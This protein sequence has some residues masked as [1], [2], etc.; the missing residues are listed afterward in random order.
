MNRINIDPSV[1]FRL[2]VNKDDAQGYFN[3]I[4]HPMDFSTI[5]GKIKSG[6]YKDIENFHTDMLLVRDNCVKYNRDPASQIRVDCDTVFGFYTVEYDKLKSRKPAKKKATGTGWDIG[7]Y[8]RAQKGAKLDMA[9]ASA[10]K[11]VQSQVEKLDDDIREKE[12][13][14]RDLTA[15]I[16]WKERLRAEFVPPVKLDQ[17]VQVEMKSK[18]RC[19]TNPTRVL[20]N[21]SARCY[22][23]NTTMTKRVDETCKALE[24]IHGADS[25]SVQDGLWLTLV[26]KAGKGAIQKYYS[27]LSRPKEGRVTKH[28]ERVTEAIVVRCVKYMYRNGSISSRKYTSLRQADLSFEC[29]GDELMTYQELVHQLKSIC[30]ELQVHEVAGVSG[31][32]RNLEDTLLKIASVY[33]EIDEKL[34]VNG[35]SLNWLK[36][37]RGHFSISVGADGAPA[38]KLKTHTS[39]LLSF[40]NLPEKVNSC[41]YQFLLFGADVPED[42]ASILN[43]VAEIASNME[44][45][46]KKVFMIG[47]TVVRFTL[48]LVPGDCKW[49]ATACGEL[50]NAAAYPSSYGNV[51][52]DDL[53]K[54]DGSLGGS[55][56]TWKPWSYLDRLAMV[57]KVALKKQEASR[58][59]VVTKYIASLHS[60][61][62]HVP[63]L[64]IYSEHCYI[65]SLHLKNNICAQLHQAILTE[66]L[67]LTDDKVIRGGIDFKNNAFRESPFGRYLVCL[68][69]KVH[70]GRIFIQVRR[71]FTENC[72]ALSKGSCGTRLL[73]VRFTGEDSFKFCQGYP[74]LIKA[75]GQNGTPDRQFRLLGPYS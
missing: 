46:E 3:L 36:K 59:D 68:R 20:P 56:S 28:K 72:A 5:K 13:C 74:Y 41:M 11:V 21:D 34:Q 64:G 30:K 75:V 33:L 54:L 70:A 62:E 66:A 10:M 6:Q 71:W 24:P 17:Y 63:T 23:S 48:E 31:C 12:E 49:I 7:M 50:S 32:Y 2:P 51:R 37:E 39:V 69:D 29:S 35:Q 15:E 45:I 22:L 57:K 9:H 4:Q 40:L 8:R 53:S 25:K 16:E 38:S 18:L 65:D 55:E 60:R 43:Y 27:N 67:I 61:Q 14:I 26:K 1:W 47:S 42:H 44:S 73:G 19:V 58:R 52:K